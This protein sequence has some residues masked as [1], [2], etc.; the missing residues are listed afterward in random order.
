MYQYSEAVLINLM[1]YSI[2]I[3]LLKRQ[4]IRVYQKEK[5]YIEY[6]NT[7]SNEEKINYY[8]NEF[9]S[10]NNEIK[11]FIDLLKAANLP[12]EELTELYIFA[13]QAR[14]E[15]ELEDNLFNINKEFLYN[16][17]KEHDEINE[18]MKKRIML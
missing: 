17:K 8:T 5:I 13:K 14:I 18:E 7:L 15:L 3:E 16:Y 11:D 6:K 1:P 4:L 9:T 10:L 12:N 2:R